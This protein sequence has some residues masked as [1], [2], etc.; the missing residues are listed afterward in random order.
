MFNP[1][2]GLSAFLSL[3][4][5]IDASVSPSTTPCSIQSVDCLLFSPFV[6][7]LMPVSLQVQHHVQSSQLTVCFSLPLL[8]P[9][10][11]SGSHELHTAATAQ[12]MPVSLRL[13]THGYSSKILHYYVSFP[14]VSGVSSKFA[15][16]L[17]FCLLL[18]HV[19]ENHIQP[20]M[21]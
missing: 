4:C 1:V 14:S 12:L 5:T 10:C 7:P 18:K 21:P 16:C 6:A 15:A 2:S 13:H 9:R 19:P 3:C 17:T 8:H 20:V 11:S